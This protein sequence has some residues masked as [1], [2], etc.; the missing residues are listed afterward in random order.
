MAVSE[1]C[2]LP[3]MARRAVQGLL[4]EHNHTITLCDANKMAFYVF[5]MKSISQVHHRYAEMEALEEY[6]CSIFSS[7]CSAEGATQM[8]TAAVFVL[9]KRSANSS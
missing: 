2:W 5:L 9:L 4:R 6:G 1:W 7:G 8:C 3:V